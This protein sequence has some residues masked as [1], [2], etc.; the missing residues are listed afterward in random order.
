MPEE[1]TMFAVKMVSSITPK[2]EL[3]ADQV[4]PKDTVSWGM[5]EY[6]VE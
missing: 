6:E 5:A 2:F 1:G 4:I 3:V